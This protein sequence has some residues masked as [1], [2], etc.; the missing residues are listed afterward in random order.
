MNVAAQ[1]IAV[2]NMHAA[3]R[4]RFLTARDN[5]SA[6]KVTALAI[7]PAEKQIKKQKK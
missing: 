1:N 3:E 2:K 7:T 6:G 4:T 5:I